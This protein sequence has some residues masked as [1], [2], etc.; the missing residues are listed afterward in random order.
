MGLQQEDLRILGLHKRPPV[1]RELRSV[2]IFIRNWPVIPI[3][4]LALLILSGLLADVLATQDP[5]KG[6]IRDRH[7]PPAWTETCGVCS[8]LLKY[9][10]AHESLLSLVFFQLVLYL[11]IFHSKIEC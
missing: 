8:G 9:A 6:G 7:I 2:W 10:D 3:A 4:I 5:R 11:N 1:I